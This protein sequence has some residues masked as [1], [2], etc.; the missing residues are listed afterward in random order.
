MFVDVLNTISADG[1]LV[2]RSMHRI[3]YFCFPQ[4]TSD[5]PAKSRFISSLAKVNVGNFAILSVP[6][7][8]LR[9]LPAFRHWLQDFPW[10]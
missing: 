1:S 5:G 8:H 9:F 10:W 7:K 4:N 6:S 2:N 3:V